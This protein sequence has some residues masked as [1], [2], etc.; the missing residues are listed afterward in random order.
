MDG[1][2]LSLATGR[3]GL[4]SLNIH[5]I[6][7]YIVCWLVALNSYIIKKIAG[8]VTEYM[9]QSAQTAFRNILHKMR[10]KILTLKFF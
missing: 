6:V 4:G 2:S 3:H 7:V 10:R 9:G 8:Y 1:L 5:K